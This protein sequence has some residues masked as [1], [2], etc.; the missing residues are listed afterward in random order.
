MKRLQPVIAE[1]EAARNLAVT[2]F[3][4]EAN[5]PVND[6]LRHFRVVLESPSSEEGDVSFRVEPREG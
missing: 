1:L 4:N 6:F 3:A 2:R 5:M